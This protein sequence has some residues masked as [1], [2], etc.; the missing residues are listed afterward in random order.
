MTLAFRSF[1]ASRFMLV[2][3]FLCAL[4]MAASPALEASK[5][6]PT[7]NELMAS[8]ELE[9]EISDDPPARTAIVPDDEADPII[10]SEAPESLSDEDQAPV[11]PQPAEPTIKL[12]PVPRV[13]PAE[14]TV[15]IGRVP[16]MNTENMLLAYRGLIA[17]LKQ[18]MGVKDVRIVTAKDYAGVQNALE[19]GSIDFAWL[20]PMAYA[21]A[22]QK[23]PMYPLAQANRRTGS[24]YRGVFITRVDSKILGIE[25]IKGRVVGFVDPESASGYLYPLYFLQRS[26]INPHEVCKKVEFLGKHDAIIPAVLAGKIDV[27]VCLEDTLQ[28]VKDK[29]ILDRLLILGKT[30]EVP[31]DIVAC[32]KDCDPKLRDAFQRAMLKTRSLK[33]KA[34]PATGLPPVL[35]F[36]P[37]NDADLDPVRGVL[38]AIDSIRQH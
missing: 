14:K 19:R 17:F 5:D 23:I 34:D 33:Q 29:R 13:P 28:A 20:G 18:E 10:P 6:A 25:E 1:P 2:S 8:G 15:L 27:G 30:Y 26:K 32:R 22:S 9:K 21:I 7:L 16:F 35:E 31:S 4:L 37:V 12:T 3:A 38:G 24:T 11:A 36:M